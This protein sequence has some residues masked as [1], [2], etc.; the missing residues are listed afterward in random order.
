[1][2]DE[3]TEALLEIERHHRDFVLIQE[4]LDRCD[5]LMRGD[6]RDAPTMRA[7][8]RRIRNVVG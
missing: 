6:W 5:R 3:L 1:M 8:L 7:S 4:V 2:S